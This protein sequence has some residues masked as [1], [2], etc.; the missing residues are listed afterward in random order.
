MSLIVLF[1][2]AGGTLAQDGGL[3]ADAGADARADVARPDAAEG[4]H[5]DDA[6]SPDGS[7]APVVDELPASE[8]P[9]LTMQVHP[10]GGVATG[11]VATLTITVLGN[12]GDEITL[13]EQSFAPFELTHAEH[14]E[15][16]APGGKTRI[17]LELS[18]LALEPG[19]HTVGPLRLRV[20]TRAGRL[21][22]VST[23]PVSVRVRSLLGNEPNAQPKPPTQPVAV[24][25]EDYT[26][27]WIAGSIG[28]ILLTALLA[29]FV[30][31]WWMRRPR[32]PKPLPP[33]R[34]PWELAL[35][36]LRALELG[37][38][39]AVADGKTAEWIDSVS[40]ALRE[41][42][43]S[44][45]GFEG[46]ESTSD[47]VI[48]RLRLVLL[49]GVSLGEITA[50]LGDC[51]LIK[52]ARVI[53]DEAQCAQIHGAAVRIVQ[54]TI[55]VLTLPTVVRPSRPSGPA[56]RTSGNPL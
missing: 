3:L 51:D 2:F 41:Y 26:L 12:E 20:L 17:A 28:A 33:P 45:Y 9:P 49:P 16:R 44:R 38:R 47:E 52:F 42:F 34:P 32:A 43:G 18:L 19:D 31:R 53:P 13:P 36:K 5:H 25:Q 4:G 48:G 8:R 27:A 54:A 30:A 6:G 23:E 7:N 10:E 37:F 40:D 29:F 24:M 11:E 21:G 1:V 46:L 15:E 35:E 14:R 39:R 56:G 55:P 50:V 22:S